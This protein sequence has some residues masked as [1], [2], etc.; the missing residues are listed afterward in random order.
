[1][2]I[3]QDLDIEDLL[4]K[5]AVSLDNPE[6]A[7]TADLL[8]SFFSGLEVTLS[9][10]LENGEPSKVNKD[11]GPFS[12][13]ALVGMA[14]L[15]DRVAKMNDADLAS[16]LSRGQ[17]N[18]AKTFDDAMNISEG[19]RMCRPDNPN[20]GWGASPPGSSYAVPAVSKA[21]AGSLE[22][23]AA[24][25]PE[26]LEK[27]KTGLSALD[28]SDE[29]VNKD[30]QRTQVVRGQVSPEEEAALY[31]GNINSETELRKSMVINAASLVRRVNALR[32]ANL[33]IGVSIVPNDDDWESRARQGRG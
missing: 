8:G 18:P 20:L 6:E 4:M 11:T 17:F 30:G 21:M 10:A 24:A 3:E 9:R 15:L 16:W 7:T 5:A 23:L 12:K 29:S 2:S 1:M 13:A 27:A 31:A 25:T 22:K 26:E 33:N 14:W 19:Q 28:P 32:K